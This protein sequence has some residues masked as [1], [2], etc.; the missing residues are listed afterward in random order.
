MNLPQFQIILQKIN[1]LD[2]NIMMDGKISSIE[3]DLMKAY[4][5]QL[6]EACVNDDTTK[7]APEPKVEAVVQTPV[8]PVV[9]PTPVS[10]APVQNTPPP[11]V[12]QPVA[13][14]PVAPVP[15]QQPVANKVVTPP[16]APVPPAAVAQPVQ[17]AEPTPTPVVNPETQAQNKLK[18]LNDRIAANTKTVA[19]NLNSP[20]G[21]SLNDRLADKNVGK[22]FNDRFTKTEN[23]TSN[24]NISA[25][26]MVVI[27]ES[28]KHLDNSS[29]APVTQPAAPVTPPP[30]PVPV[31]PT[32]VAKVT[33]APTPTPIPTPQP[34]RGGSVNINEIY[35]LFDDDQASEAAG[36]WGS[37]PIQ[38]LS[39]SIGLNDKISM[40]KE[41]FND[42]HQ[43]F[44]N[45]LTQLNS[46]G[47]FNEAKDYMMRNLVTVFKWNEGK[48]LERAKQLI[49]L[50]RRR[51]K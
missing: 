23:T 17:P 3:K 29:S 49:N 46:L 50:V 27:P 39:K 21:K 11:A 8:P 35:A 42:D 19:D 7:A 22:T 20:K 38:D 36:K 28:L 12:E 26:K 6:Y 33:P 51:Y 25:P 45:S 41:L 24:T 16:P 48:K 47:N 9:Q 32:P 18:D 40:I 14:Q 13:T 34:V 37:T 30:A 31:A 15:T 5:S 4:V 44:N 1:A 43:A 2:K 10:Q